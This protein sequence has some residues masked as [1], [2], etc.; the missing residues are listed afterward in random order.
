[1]KKCLSLILAFTMALALALPASAAAPAQLTGTAEAANIQKYGNVVLSLTCE[2]V[3][4]AG[5]T[6]GDVVTVSFLDQ[7]L[8]IPFCNNYSDVD[9]GSPALFARDA[10]TYVLV[11]INMGDFA[12]TYGIAT[13]TTNEDKTFVWNYN[14]GVTGPVTFTI[15]LKEAGG[16]YDEY[17]MHQL[18]YTTERA[19]YAELSDEQFANFRAVTTT[20]M[21]KGV[22]YRTSSPVNPEAGRNAYADAALRNAG[23]TVVMNLADDAASVKG[24]EGYAASYY[25][26]TKYIALNMGVDFAAAEFQSKLAEGLRFFAE[27]PGVYAIHCTEGKDRAGFVTALLECMMGASYDEVVADYMT[28][29]YN[30]YGVKADEARYGV[31][32]NSNIVKSLQRAFDVADL[33]SADLAAEAVAYLKAIGLTDAEIAALRANLSAAPAQGT[34]YVVSEGDCLWN[35]AYKAYG[36][37]WDFYRIAEA[38]GIPSPYVIYVGQTLR[39]PQ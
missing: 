16:Y 23:V 18:K 39:I 14:E 17:I 29:F 10:D 20:G 5:Y 1:M 2:E 33:R 21:G 9:S 31:I 26:T 6:F 22:L 12:T 27:N 36:T 8:D 4:A 35:I 19:D 25:A 7:S 28:T 32:A 3:K 13:K 11:A 30:Y 24:Y 37:G 34:D 38:N 15:S